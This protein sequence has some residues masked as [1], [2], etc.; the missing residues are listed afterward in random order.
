MAWGRVEEPGIGL[1]TEGNGL[2]RFSVQGCE[3]VRALEAPCR[4]THWRSVGLEGVGKRGWVNISGRSG[5][6]GAIL[7]REAASLLR[8]L[9]QGGKGTKEGGSTS[10]AGNGRDKKRSSVLADLGGGTSKLGGCASNGNGREGRQEERRAVS[11]GRL[12]VRPC[13]HV[14]V[15][16]LQSQSSRP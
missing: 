12:D 1:L 14:L 2:S 10:N 3:G 13:V 7:E 9:G 6:L 5:I 4:L 16:H 11:W 8:S 15:E